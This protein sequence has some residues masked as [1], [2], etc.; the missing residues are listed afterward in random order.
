MS[1]ETFAG[2][3][4]KQTDNFKLAYEAELVKRFLGVNKSTAYHLPYP[5]TNEYGVTSAYS[6][7]LFIQY[8][9]PPIGEPC[10]QWCVIVM[11]LT[12]NEYCVFRGYFDDS[13]NWQ[14]PNVWLKVFNSPELL[15]GWLQLIT[16]RGEPPRPSQLTPFEY[17]RIIDT[18][19]AV[20]PDEFT[21]AVKNTPKLV[22]WDW[23]GAERVLARTE[24]VLNG[25]D[26]A[27]LARIAQMFAVP[28]DVFQQPGF[29][30]STVNDLRRW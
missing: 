6:Y 22:V 20:L 26:A 23:E 3:W 1:E 4:S 27:S 8:A 29:R 5:L 21:D 10:E 28:A 30:S 16:T 14:H 25:L 11:R 24:V 18:L 2:W 19:V 17:E 15:L 13:G 12:Q 7:P 9:D